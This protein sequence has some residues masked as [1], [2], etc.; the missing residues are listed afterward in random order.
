MACHH[1]IFREVL[2]LVRFTQA[3]LVTAVCGWPGVVLCLCVVRFAERDLSFQ[4]WDSA[5]WQQHITSE[6]ALF[7]ARFMALLEMLELQRTYWLLC[8]SLDMPTEWPDYAVNQDTKQVKF[9]RCQYKSCSA[10]W[11][12]AASSAEAVF[13]Q[14]QLSSPLP[15]YS[16]VDQLSHLQTAGESQLWKW[17]C[18]VKDYL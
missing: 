17:M 5:S 18:D 10:S 16:L 3:A 6:E 9:A 14:E 13:Q 15:L 12:P 11:L 7:S 1:R 2:V 4:P 8:C